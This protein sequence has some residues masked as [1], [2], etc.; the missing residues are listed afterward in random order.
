M[1]P[2]LNTREAAQVLGI[3][4]TRLSHWRCEGAG[5][6]Y[7]RLGRSVRYSEADLLA[8]VAARRVVPTSTDQEVTEC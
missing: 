2:T 3:S 6:A 5:P 7:A 8:F 4:A 1:T